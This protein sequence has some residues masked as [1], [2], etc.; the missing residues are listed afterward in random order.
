MISGARNCTL[1]QYFTSCTILLPQSSPWSLRSSSSSSSS[2]CRS[3]KTLCLSRRQPSPLP[4]ADF[5]FSRI[6]FWRTDRRGYLY[7]KVD[8]NG[9][10]LQCECA[11]IDLA[12]EFVALH[13]KKVCFLSLLIFNISLSISLWHRSS[14]K[15]CRETTY[16]SYFNNYTFDSD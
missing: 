7:L 15:R 14:G 3:S 4:P 12:G 9:S 6:L 10:T 1:L 13:I 5:F 16:I 2:S 8:Q 11:L